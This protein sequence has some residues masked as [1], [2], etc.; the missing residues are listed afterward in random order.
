MTSEL[1][2]HWPVVLAAFTGILFSVGTFVV[3]TFS[4]FTPALSA[5]FGWDP[6]QISIA[7]GLFNVSLIVASP[8]AG[9]LVDLHGGRRVVLISTALFG[10]VFAALSVVPGTE[11]CTRAVHSDY[12]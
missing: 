10:I 12:T 11:C 3:Y 2:L 1:R 6:L 4:I 7:L 9:R 8:L 5:E